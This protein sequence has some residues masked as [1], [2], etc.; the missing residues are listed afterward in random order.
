MPQKKET[1]RTKEK[2]TGVKVK[3]LA[4]KKDPKGGS[5]VWPSGPR[6]GPDV[7]KGQG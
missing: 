4:T 3:D 2:K 6:P 5:R 1:T 7:F